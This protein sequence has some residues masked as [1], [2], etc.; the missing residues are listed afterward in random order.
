[1]TPAAVYFEIEL[2][3]NELQTI[4]LIN[5]LGYLRQSVLD[6]NK[7]SHNVDCLFIASDSKNTNFTI[8]QLYN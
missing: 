6:F 2:I 3:L 7:I 1:M 4:S 5:D 8:L